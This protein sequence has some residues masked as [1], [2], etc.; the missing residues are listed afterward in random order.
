[1]IPSRVVRSLPIGDEAQEVAVEFEREI[2]L[3][4][5]A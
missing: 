2:P 4:L 1:M 3:A 5:A